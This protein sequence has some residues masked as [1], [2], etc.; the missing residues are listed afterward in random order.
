MNLQKKKLRGQCQTYEVSP[1]SIVTS[2]FKN[3]NPPS[4][5]N[6]VVQLKGGTNKYALSDNEI[7]Q[8]RRASDGELKL[9]LYMD[10]IACLPPRL[11]KADLQVLSENEVLQW[12]KETLNKS[13]N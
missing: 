5:T 11:R 10:G 4:L 8:L 2:I 9:V 3:D 6:I 1:G 12:T 13:G 7:S